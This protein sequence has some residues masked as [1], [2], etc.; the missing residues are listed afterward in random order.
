MK[1][2]DIASNDGCLLIEFQKEGYQVIGVDPAENLCRLAEENG[3][4]SIAAFWGMDA[5]KKV[6]Q[7]LGKLDVITATNVFAHVDD[8]HGFLEAV[9]AALDDEGILVIEFPY[10][11]NLIKY[12]EFDTIYHEHLSYFLIKP[13]LTLFHQQGM[14][15]MNLAE[16]DIHGGSV[17]VFVSKESNKKIP[18]NEKA[19]QH[20]LEL[21]QKEGLHTLAPYVNLQKNAQKIREALR[22]RLRELRALGKK[23]AAYGASAKGNTFINYCRLDLN[24]IGFIIDDTPHKQGKLYAGTHIPVVPQAWLRQEKPD[25]VLI[26]AWNFASEII[27]KSPEYQTQGGK[28]II[29]IPELKII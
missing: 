22:E 20:F 11:R 4:P 25:Y 13:L 23:I 17:R 8:L 27:S 26:L 28:Y 24:D 15:L 7:R 3:V 18:V 9:Y 21:E 6:V 16:F 1:C 2:L 12:N 29:A 10:M 14:K 19:I 5:A